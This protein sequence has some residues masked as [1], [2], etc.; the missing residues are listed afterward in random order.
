MRGLNIMKGFSTLNLTGT[1]V[2]LE[3]LTT[4]RI[5]LNDLLKRYYTN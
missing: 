2:T 1:L 5:L 4:S 3:A